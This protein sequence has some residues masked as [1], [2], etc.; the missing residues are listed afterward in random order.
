MG[1]LFRE[2]AER[3]AWAADQ[4]RKRLSGLTEVHNSSP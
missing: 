2:D 1:L 4:A 3:A